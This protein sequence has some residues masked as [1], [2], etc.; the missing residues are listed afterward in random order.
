MKT[1]LF[2][3][4]PF[5]LLFGCKKEDTPLSE[6]F[7]VSIEVENRTNLSQK[8]GPIT[9]IDT[10]ICSGLRADYV[11]LRI[12]QGNFQEIPIFNVG[13]NK[14]TSSIKLPAGTHLISEFLVYNNNNTPNNLGDDVL[15]F[16]TP[17]IG[18]AF[19]GYV[20]TPLEKT[21]QV[22]TD[23]K[24]ELKM[25]VACYDPAT[26][27]NFGFVYFQLNQVVIR[28]QWFFGNFCIRNKSEYVGS[29]YSQQA[30]W[31]LS[32]GPYIDV[33]AIFKVEV[34]RNGVLQNTFLN[35]VQGEKLAVN[36][37]D[38]LDE[39]EEFIFKLFIYVKT[40]TTF[41]YVLFKEF[42]FNDVSNIPQG[43]DGVVD[44]VLGGCYDPATPPDVIIPEYMNL[45][46][47]CT[48]TI[49]AQPSTMGGYVDATLSNIP[50]GYI[51]Q[52]G[53]YP[54]N[55]ADHSTLIY[56]GVAYNMDVYSSLYQD[57]LPLFARG[58]ER[59]KK[60]NWLYN[61]L[62]YFGSYSWWDLQQ[63]LW[64]FDV[65]Q[66]NGL[67]LGGVPA[68]TTKAQEMYAAANLYGGNYVAL[69]GSYVAVIFV[70]AGTPITATS[71]SIQTMFIQIE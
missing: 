27:A 46:S 60:I 69:P 66:W 21:F 65:P 33:P 53:V 70:P 42:S 18:S 64:L 26:H 31:S 5:L 22:S 14:Y 39:N 35:S 59:W 47:T 13:G 29:L 6:L 24:N 20:T 17:H 36:Y 28:E 8:S 40:G 23:K 62:D 58:E 52:N 3:L 12:N 56:I 50:T 30:N 44:F 71:G 19:A 48:Y 16:A 45:P 49:T 68:L 55:C 37:G 32:P 54:S 38:Y 2:L 57:K 34:W 25:D 43:N 67:P 15:I 11:R 10:V 41:G 1:K 63:A 61:H 7:E 4:V 9:K 51:L